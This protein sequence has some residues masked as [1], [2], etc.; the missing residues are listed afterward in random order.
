MEKV[1]IYTTSEFMGNVVKIEGK[2]IAHGRRPWAQ[3][4]AVP[5]VQ[6]RKKRAKKD[7]GLIKSGRKPYLLIVEG[8]DNP[9]PDDLYGAAEVR[10]G[11]AVSKGRYMS[12]DE[13][14]TKDFNQ[15]IDAEIARGNVKVVADY[16]ER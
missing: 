14:W 5:F 11:V 2:L 10:D 16:R 6:F 12:F 1:T 3:Y 8:W 15:T 7:T 4:A 13:R 9:D